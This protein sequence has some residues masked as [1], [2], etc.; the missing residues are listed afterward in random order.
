[1]YKAVL[2]IIALRAQGIKS[3]QAIGE[4]LGLTRDTVNTYMYQAHKK[5]WIN[6]DTFADPEDTLE[7]VLKHKVVKNLNTVLD[8]TAEDGSLSGRAVEVSLEVAKGTGL[9]KQHQVVKGEGGAPVNFALKVQVDMPPVLQQPC[10]RSGSI[11]GQP[12]FAEAE[13]IEVKEEP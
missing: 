3:S 6:G 10:A 12:Y 1:M 11:G 4:Q 9:L 2:A 8:E 5:G 13:V 7:Y